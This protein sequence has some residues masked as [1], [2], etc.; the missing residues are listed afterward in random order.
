VLGLITIR[1]GKTL[2]LTKKKESDIWKIKRMVSSLSPSK[3][4]G[5]NSDLSLLPKLMTTLHTFTSPTKTSKKRAATSRFRLRN[6]DNILSKL[7]KL[8]KDLLKISC[9]I[10]IIIPQQLLSLE[11]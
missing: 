6:R 2:T 7:T 3:P 11:F 8:L 1:I 4:S 10:A 5:A 9:R